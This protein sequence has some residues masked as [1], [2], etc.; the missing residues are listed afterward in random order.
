M[1]TPLVTIRLDAPGITA[2]PAEVADR[3]RRE[4]ATAVTAVAGTLGLAIAPIVE[5]ADSASDDVLVIVNGS[6]CRYPPDLAKNVHTYLTGFAAAE[7]FYGRLRSWISAALDLQCGETALAAEYLALL[8]VQAIEARASVLLTA[9]PPAESGGDDNEKARCLT[10][11]RRL[12]DLGLPAGDVD[13][14]RAAL[15]EN[16]DVDDA[17]EQLIAERAPDEWAVLVAPGYLRE[18]SLADIADPGKVTRYFLGELANDLPFPLP[19]LHLLSDPDLRDGCFRFRINKTTTVPILGVPAD[20]ILLY[21]ATPEQLAEQAPILDP[22]ATYHGVLVLATGQEDLTARGFLPCTP[23]VYLG[24]NLDWAIRRRAGRLVNV[25]RVSA[26]LE[27][28]QRQRPAQVLMARQRLRLATMTGILRA[29]ADEGLPTK[30]LPAI[31]DR[32]LE[33]DFRGQDAHIDRLAWTRSG[34]QEII[35]AAFSTGFRRIRI[36]ELAPHTQASAV[37]WLAAGGTDD[38]VQE[39]LLSALRAVAGADVTVP[40]LVADE[41]RVATWL[42]ARGEFP[43]LRLLGATELPVDFTREEI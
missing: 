36:R 22:I 37:S 31:L 11:Q 3:F 32:M 23:P 29:L 25:A 24:I 16:D 27:Q 30:D 26:A 13:E 4:V 28:L 34:M 17:A 6:R 7:K 43:D 38:S 2:V 41:A 1:T 9:E 5:L 14:I 35:G 39:D 40:V 18:L 21:G 19:G 12:L 8:T 42:A 20:R 10:V 33:Y 15:R